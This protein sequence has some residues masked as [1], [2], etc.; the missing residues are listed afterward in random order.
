MYLSAQK[1]RDSDGAQ[2][3][4]VFVYTHRGVECPGVDW[5]MPDVGYV[6][7]QCPGKIVAAVRSITAKNPGVLTFLDI[8]VSEQ[9][10]AHAV[11]TLLQSAA[12]HWPG[13]RG[14]PT[15]WHAGPLGLR[16]YAARALRDEDRPGAELRELKDA[17]LP[18]LGDVVS[19]QR[20]SARLDVRPPGPIIVERHR[21]PVGF[22]FELTQDAARLL[23]AA[24]AG[25]SARSV[26]VSTENLDAFEIFTGHDIEDEVV[27][28]LSGLRLE[29][30]DALAGAVVV[31]AANGQEVWRSPGA[32]D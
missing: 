20:G 32:T 14:W 4:N 24:G 10:L 23:K 21:T 2:G 11:G 26:S 6:A 3:V 9:L 12:A 7:D 19:E 5:G 25:S 16:F 18:I 15:T 8:A 28:T 30:I 13:P 29:Q 27:Q 22:R 1:V 17:L 31:D